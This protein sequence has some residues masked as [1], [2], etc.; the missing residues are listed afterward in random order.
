MRDNKWM[1]STAL[2]RYGSTGYLNNPQQLRWFAECVAIG[3][4]AREIAPILAI[5]KKSAERYRNDP[6]VKAEAMRLID[7]R[8]VRV[9]SRTDAIIVHRLETEADDMSVETLLKV[10]KEFLQGPL[11]AAA[12]GTDPGADVI[13]DAIESIENDPDF[14]AELQALLERQ[15]AS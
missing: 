13:N 7:D 4:S 5:S 12:Q 6:R 10:R 8:V 2:R 11:R 1:A 14:A 9:T 15:P 3:L